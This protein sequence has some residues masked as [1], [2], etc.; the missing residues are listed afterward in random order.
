M[1]NQEILILILVNNKF[2]SIKLLK[3]LKHNN[4]ILLNLA[5]LIFFKLE[6]ITKYYQKN[7]FANLIICFLYIFR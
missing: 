4:N 1:H 6:N 2:T 7:I 5:L 3:V